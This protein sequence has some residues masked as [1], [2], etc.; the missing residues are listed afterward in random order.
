MAFRF[1]E[2]A[3]PVVE[4]QPVLKRR[5]AFAVF[6]PAAHDVQIGM[7]VTIGVEENGAEILRERVLRELLLAAADEASVALL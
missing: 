2:V 6:T 7:A 5:R 3:P 1:T 4:I